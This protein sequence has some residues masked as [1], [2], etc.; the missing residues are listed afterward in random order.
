MDTN[1]SESPITKSTEQQLSERRRFYAEFAI[2]MFALNHIN[3]HLDPKSK[4]S[5]RRTP[6]AY[7]FHQVAFLIGSC[8]AARL[9]EYALENTSLG[10]WLKE[11][12]RVHDQTQQTSNQAAH[13]SLNERVDEVPT[14]KIFAQKPTPSINKPTI[15]SQDFL[16]IEPETLMGT[17]VGSNK[18]PAVK[19]NFKIS[20]GNNESTKAYKTN[21]YGDIV[22]SED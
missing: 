2:M 7:A 17:A 20:L 13:T 1:S 4:I 21:R 3:L 8:G 22:Y 12:K 16:E 18:E 15:T 19:Q 9:F 10:N 6:G 11:R 5:L 14:D